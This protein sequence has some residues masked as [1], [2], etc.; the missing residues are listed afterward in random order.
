L[1]RALGYIATIC[2][3]SAP[4]CDDP[5]YL[6]RMKKLGCFYLQKADHSLL[7]HSPAFLEQMLMATGKVAFAGIPINELRPP[8]T[9]YALTGEL[10]VYFEPWVKSRRKMT[11]LLKGYDFVPN[12]RPFNEMNQ[13]TYVAFIQLPID[14]VQGTNARIERLMHLPEVADVE[15][16]ENGYLIIYE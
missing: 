4:G 16:S 5:I 8:Y 13:G 1:I 15:M 3:D 6:E 14:Y 12:G 11:R 10:K 7:D 9:P 2:P